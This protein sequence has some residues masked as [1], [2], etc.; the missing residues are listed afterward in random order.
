MNKH[1]EITV[2]TNPVWA[3][4]ISDLLIDKAG[5]SGVITEEKNYEDEKILN[6]DIENVKGY[7]SYS[8][9][10]N[11]E[12]VRKI[13]LSE[14]EKFILSGINPDNLGSWEVNSREVFEEEW[15]ENWKKFWH[16][17]KIGQKIVICPTWE[18]YTAENNDIIIKLDPGSAFGTG[19]HPT[20]RT[21]I[22]ALEEII[23]LFKDEILMADIGAGS[24]V[25]AIAGIKLGVSCVFGVDNDPAVLPVASEN[26]K[27]NSVIN[28]CNFSAGTAADIDGKFDIVTANIL[29]EVLLEI[30]P[31]LN[32]LL[33]KD[34]M[35]I[36]SGIIKRKQLLIEESLEKNNLK[37][38]KLLEEENWITPIA[39]KKQK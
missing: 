28:K 16:P 22:Q 10:F 15:S 30:M 29:A 14:K 1:I 11:L 36:L 26:A 34:G 4:Y 21:C 5:C 32:R 25:L 2:K 37:T 23:P 6:A 8:K 31:E 13:L 20:T 17:E 27:K 12:N 3:E 9:D 19:A 35:I 39:V 18:E 38:W 7:L 33:K 24:G